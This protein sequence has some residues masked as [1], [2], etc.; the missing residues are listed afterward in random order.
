MQEIARLFKIN[1]QMN[2][3]NVGENNIWPSTTI[4]KNFK[5]WKTIIINNAIIINK[6]TEKIEN[7]FSVNKEWYLSMNENTHWDNLEYIE[8][9]PDIVKNEFWENV[10]MIVPLHSYSIEKCY[11]NKNNEKRVQIINPH[12]TWIKF[13][14][15]LEQCKE[16]FNRGIIGID[17]DEMFR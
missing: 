8:S 11:T 4:V 17:I 6:K 1:L 15:S 13:D 12:H 10:I 2:R 7:K 3:K 16:I 5:I 14:I 9:T